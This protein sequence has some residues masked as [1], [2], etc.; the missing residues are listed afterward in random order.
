M[1][2]QEDEDKFGYSSCLIKRDSAQTAPLER[3]RQHRPKFIDKELVS[4]PKKVP[5]RTVLKRKQT[6]DQSTSPV[7]NC[8]DFK[9]TNKNYTAGSYRT[10]Y[11]S[12]KQAYP[13]ESISPENYIK[14]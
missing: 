14:I 3:H 5:T 4:S 8:I 7:R 10:I 11:S 13:M 6:Y 12:K 2:Q 1:E 9:S